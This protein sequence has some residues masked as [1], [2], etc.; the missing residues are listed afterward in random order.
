MQKNIKNKHVAAI[1]ARDSIVL[2]FLFLKQNYL[3]SMFRAYW[4]PYSSGASAISTMI[5]F[6]GTG[7]RCHNFPS[8]RLRA[9][10]TQSAF[11]LKQ[12]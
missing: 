12:E 4:Q 2:P 8:N 1:V 10:Q 5:K 6:S 9:C 3:C 11:R 7:L